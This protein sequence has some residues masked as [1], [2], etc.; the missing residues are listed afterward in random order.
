[1]KRYEGLS[2]LIGPIET[3]VKEEEKCNIMPN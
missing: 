1:M 3:V 2:K